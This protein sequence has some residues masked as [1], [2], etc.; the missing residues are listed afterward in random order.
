MA[1]RNMLIFQHLLE[2]RL[3]IIH[4][5]QI[6]W[7]HTHKNLRFCEHKDLLKVIVIL[8]YI[9]SGQAEQVKLKIDS[10]LMIPAVKTEENS[11]FFMRRMEI[12]SDRLQQVNKAV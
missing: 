5:L 2:K 7:E 6:C 10:E 4:D 3:M 11:D 9:S 12:I 1:N 8:K